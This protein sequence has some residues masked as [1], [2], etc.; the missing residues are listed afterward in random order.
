MNLKPNIETK[1]NRI[2]EILKIQNEE[3]LSFE[4]ACIYLN[5]KRSYLYKLTHLK[6]IPFYRPNNKKIYFSRAELN[7]WIFQNKSYSEQE[8]QAEAEDYIKERGV[9]I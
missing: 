6:K 3:P 2:M 8:I 5:F 4:Q 7:K 9:G 1:L